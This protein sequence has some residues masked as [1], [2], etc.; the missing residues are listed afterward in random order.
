MASSAPSRF[1]IKP[2]LV[3]KRLAVPLA[4]PV[5]I[6]AVFAITLLLGISVVSLQYVKRSQER[7][8]RSNLETSL[9]SFTELINVWQ[10]QNLSAMQVLVNSVQGKIL[11]KKALDEGGNNPNTN[12]ELNDWLYPV[13]TV[14]GF[15]GFSVINH[16]RVLVSAS[17][18][19]YR[20][21]LVV[22]QEIIE[23]L[24][25]ALAG[26]AAISRPVAAPYTINGPRGVQPA[27]TL[28]QNM[29]VLF[30]TD[31]PESGYFCLS[32]NTS[33]SFF[34]I[35]LKGRTGASGEIYAIDHYGRFMTP[36]RFIDESTGGRSLIGEAV[37]LPNRLA[38]KPEQL[39]DMADFLINMEASAIKIYYPDYRGVMVVGAGRWFKEMELGVIVEQDV[40]EAFAPY[41]ASRNIII[42][43]TFSAVILIVLL[44]VGSLINRQQLAIREGRFRA[45]LKNIP[46]AVYMHS[47]DGKLIVVNPA[48]CE[49]MRIHKD[50]LLGL[51]IRDVPA[52][53]WIKPL[54]EEPAARVETTVNDDHIIELC[55]PAGAPK[56]F[57][58]LRFPVV[59]NFVRE[60]QAIAC[61]LVD[62][63]ER[64]ISRQRLANMNQQLEYLVQERT[65]ELMVAKDEALAASQAKADFLA[66]M[67]HEIRT[68]LNAIIGL[69][70]V[71]L[72]DKPND[73]QRTYLEKMRGSGEHLLNVINDILNFSRI[74]AGKLSLDNE[75]LSVEKLMYKVMDL[76]FDS[77]KF[78]GLDVK[79]DIDPRVPSVLMG[80][81]LRLQ[82]IL[83]NFSANA[84]KF[85]D[86]GKI[87]LRVRYLGEKN[88]KVNLVFEVVDTGVGIEP[89]KLSTL[90][91]P[92][93]QVDNSSARRFEGTGLGLC[94]CKNL[95]DLMQGRIEVESHPNEGSCFR[96]VVALGVANSS[97]TAL[98]A[99]TEYAPINCDVLVVE[100]N[101]LNQ[102]IIVA[103][104]ETMGVKVVCVGSAPEAITAITEQRFDLVL[105]D[106]QLP[107]MDGVEATARI[108]TMDEGKFLPIVALTANALPGDKERY[109]AA[110]M[111]DYIAKPIN[112]VELYALLARKEQQS[113]AKPTAVSED[114]LFAALRANG[115]ATE[116]ALHHLMN[117]VA[118]YRRLLERFALERDN[119]V[120][121]FNIMLASNQH[122]DVLLH[123]HSL[124]SLVGSLGMTKLESIVFRVE[125]QLRSNS[126]EPLAI[127]EFN[128][129]FND[130][131][132]I[133]KQAM[134]L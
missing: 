14:M 1:S 129:E 74:E 132:K 102:E 59:S 29:C 41:F 49:L 71:A 70:H 28:I 4:N 130:H 20:G 131:I 85:T 9:N 7:I 106:I 107:G 104:L 63:T 45:L 56:Y 19:Q 22:S 124:K 82:Q 78:K 83:I 105:M 134:A 5:I 89:Q 23:V 118:L 119:F 67:S 110:G 113:H 125:Q 95:A 99:T 115:I 37:R 76:I 32:F 100:D 94:I 121:E 77:A 30:Q 91:Q 34:P 109:L 38:G 44:A 35:F 58:S 2:W 18:E 52:P 26:Q 108:R 43:L 51:N 79:V 25:K 33:T 101:P 39:T 112:P 54:L 111:D 122:E 13:L 117:N 8:V 123:I 21:K 75:A 81:Q 87:S 50:D 103:L 93:H 98:P 127:T 116:R 27:G 96:L 133:V 3:A 24:D 10:R 42:G 97:V 73:K 80:D 60:H 55:D 90:F 17:G 69:A 36:S 47:L 84:V 66:N 65:Q 68:P 114:D 11:L 12:K 126:L 72:A 86:R 40:D 46:I 128:R 61:V 48:F 15:D 92:F 16:D 88:N 64:M 6:L 120:D 57:R 53:R 31:M 62:V